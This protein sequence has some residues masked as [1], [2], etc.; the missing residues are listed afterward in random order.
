MD[1]EDELQE[2]DTE[3]PFTVKIEERKFIGQSYD[4]S[5][6]TLHEQWNSGMLII[7]EYQRG[8]IWDVGK[9]SRLI[10]SLILNIP[11]PPIY[12][13]ELDDGRSEIV[14]GHQRV[15][16]IVNFLSN[17]TK[18]SGL[19]LLTEYN[20]L[21]LD[22][23]PL[24]EQRILRM[25]IM[26]TVI[27]S[28][29]S[30][31]NMKFEIFE[32]LN[33]GSIMLNAQ[34]LRNALYRGSFNNKLRQLIHNELFRRLLGRKSPHKRM[35]EEELILRFFALKDNYSSYKAPLKRFLNEY[36][37]SNK[38]ADVAFLEDLQ[39]SFIRTLTAVNS[40][41]GAAAFRVTDTQGH[42]TE[43]ALN[44]ALYDAQMLAF[45][46]LDEQDLQPNIPRLYIELATMYEKR[47]FQESIGRA[48]NDPSRLRL[49][50]R[51]I[52]RALQRAGY[53]LSVPFDID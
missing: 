30:H 32:R 48:T 53:T 39:S 52:V 5:I 51:E 28:A 20:G 18:L 3:E 16:A 14:D 1:P 37:D 38:N 17:T 50:V 36:M 29:D 21:T 8:F 2:M 24:R 13:A 10:E 19:W 23:L 27:I 25:R 11:I 44:R 40:V 33:T 35:A 7:P 9:A 6:Q 15:R 45:S 46:W 43:R 22:K 26:R 49:R 31:P 12:M 47:D 42:P 4:L 34:E 41:F